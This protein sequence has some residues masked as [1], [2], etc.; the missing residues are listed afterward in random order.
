MNRKIFAL[1]V[2]VALAVLI[3]SQM[4]APTQPQA[5]LPA[6]DVTTVDLPFTPVAPPVV[7]PKVPPSDGAGYQPKADPKCECVNCN[8]D[9]LEKRVAALEQKVNA[10]GTARPVAS[11][12][13]SGVTNYGSTGVAAPRSTVGLPYGA[14]VT[15]ERVVS[16]TPAPPMQMQPAQPVRNVGRAVVRGTCRIVNGVRVCD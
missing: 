5:Q 4:F 8:C 16:S 6:W 2:V 15:S 10:Y 11:N 9:E 7:T 12:G 3:G 13:S 1:P 14:V